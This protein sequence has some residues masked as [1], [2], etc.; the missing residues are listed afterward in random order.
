[1]SALLEAE[2]LAKAQVVVK[3]SLGVPGL[4]P[5]LAKLTLKELISWAEGGPQRAGLVEALRQVSDQAMDA[6]AASIKGGIDMNA[7]SLDMQI[8]RD[9]NG[10]PLPISQQDFDNIQIDGLVPVIIDIKPASSVAA[11]MQ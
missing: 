8:R 1:L 2:R 4:S 6:A 9:G 5:E 7:A 3:Q 10:V 11:L